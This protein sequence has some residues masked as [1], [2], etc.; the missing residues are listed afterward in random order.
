MS[1]PHN[2]SFNPWATQTPTSFINDSGVG[3][4]PYNLPTNNNFNNESAPQQYYNNKFSNPFGLPISNPADTYNQ[5]LTAT[6][7]PI[8]QPQVASQLPTENMFG[9]FGTTGNNGAG[10]KKSSTYNPVIAQNM[11]SNFNGTQQQWDS[12]TH[13]EQQAQILASMGQKSGWEQ[14]GGIASGVGSVMGGIAG[15]YGAYQNAEYQKRQENMQRRILN[16]ENA[17]K[18]AFAKASG[19][20]Y[21]PA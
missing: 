7:G 17:N 11:P 1:K 4:N 15:L 20:T 14:A 9:D 16:S 3:I 21:V 19:G 12:L 5:N 10:I 18:S 2:S 8:L 6:T 13:E